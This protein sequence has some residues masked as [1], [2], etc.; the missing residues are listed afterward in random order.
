MTT[1]AILM[2]VVGDGQGPAELSVG[3][4][5]ARAFSAH[6]EAVFIRPDPEAAFEYAGFGATDRDAL[7]R[8]M[9]QRID[10][11]GRADAQRHRRRFGTLC[12][13][14]G[15]PK[16]HR[17]NPEPAA[18]ADWRTLKG[19]PIDILPTAARRGDLTLFTASSARYTPL[20][21]NLLEVTLLR[22]GRPVLYV[23]EGATVARFRRPLVAWDGL[24]GAARAVSALIGLADVDA[25][26]TVLHVTEETSGETPDMADVI[27]HVGW[28]GMSA[29]AMIEPRG[30]RSVG[31]TL[32]DVAAAGGADLLVMGG[33]G[34]ARYREALIGGVTRFVLRHARLPVLMA[35]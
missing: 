3:V 22:S 6:L 29:E 28:H 27:A 33:Y 14:A 24:S 17:P 25:G 7:E 12:R 31:A 11:T 20:F 30:F 23:P 2:P 4:A 15:V 10:T 35:H 32:L 21:E 34:H 1:R 26:A 8:Q 19:E 16:A 18:S 9:R 13:K 5:L